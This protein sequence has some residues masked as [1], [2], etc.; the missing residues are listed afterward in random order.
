MLTNS[1]PGYIQDLAITLCRNAEMHKLI[2]L[3]NVCEDSKAR[4]N[5]IIYPFRQRVLRGYYLSSKANS[6]INK[7]IDTLVY[8]NIEVVKLIKSANIMHDDLR[9]MLNKLK[10]KIDAKNNTDIDIEKFEES[11]VRYMDDN[12]IYDFLNLNTIYKEIK[13]DLELPVQ[14]SQDN[15]FA[16]GNSN[17]RTENNSLLI[18]NI[19]D[20]LVENSNLV[21]RYDFLLDVVNEAIRIRSLLVRNGEEELIKVHNNKEIKR[22]L[23]DVENYQNNTVL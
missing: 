14:I 8:N 15:N 17:Q 19:T 2:N 9:V 13:S 1:N 20:N 18:K 3:K 16:M 21:S 10:V 6:R 22:W 11:E 5:E 12:N 4:I 23:S 7:K